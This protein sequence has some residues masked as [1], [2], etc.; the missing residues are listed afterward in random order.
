MLSGGS[1]IFTAIISRIMIKRLIYN[2]HVLGCVF[3]MLGFMI[4]GYA[5]IL[6]SQRDEARFSQSDLIIGIIMNTVYMMMSALHSNVQELILRKKAINVKRMIGLEGQFGLIWSF[7][8]CIIAS[9][10]LCPNEGIC[11]KEGY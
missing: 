8:F 6:G 4:I 10:I 3:S 5:G 7:L 2:H 1:I 11:L 9:F